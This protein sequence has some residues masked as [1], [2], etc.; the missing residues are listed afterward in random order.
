V[1]GAVRTSL[2]AAAL[3]AL[4]AARA[5][6]SPFDSW[7]R[8]PYPVANGFSF[9]VGDGEGGGTYTDPAGTRHDGWYVATHM[10]DSY[11]LG[12]HTG[13]D[14]NGRGG[15]DTDFGQPVMAVATGKVVVAGRFE[16]PWGGVVMI[17]HIVLEGH[18]KRRVR[19]Q[20]A[21][22]SRIDVREG[23]IVRGRAV[24]GAIGKDPEG[25]Y[26]AHLHLEIRSD[27]GV[28]PTYWPSDHGRDGDWIRKH[29]LD[30][31]AFIRAHRKLPDPA[32]ERV[33]VLVDQ[34]RYR[35]QVRVGGRVTRE[36][37]IG[38]GQESGQKR[39]EGDLRTPK[40]IYFVVDKQKG[41]FGGEWGEYFGGYW[42]KVNYPGPADAAWGRE[43]AVIDEATA[44]AIV[45]AWGER[46]LTPQN[47]PLGSGIGFH[48][49][50]SEWKKRSG[51][52]LSFGCV[53][54][55]NKDI[56]GWFDEVAMGTM[57]V[58]F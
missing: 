3:A 25:A 17:E 28:G 12:I 55:H 40:G 24:I 29:Y 30:P 16:N 34:A 39:R 47:T 44:A 11:A 50:A 58:I 49:W 13:E 8:N 7:L 23:Q 15:G 54:L 1:R 45:A 27:L 43:N 20:Y 33:L 52:N 38:L 51:A 32:G 41:S 48:G 2:A 10:G 26:P 18:E 9:P 6:A 35:M 31:S 14:W 5:A 56:A 21:H 36:L 37:E 42:I 4:P 19:S 22:L 57:V 53:V 46:K